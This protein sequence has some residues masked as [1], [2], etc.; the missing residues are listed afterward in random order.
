MVFSLAYNAMAQQAIRYELLPSKDGP[1]AENVPRSETW[2]Q[3]IGHGT[4][5]PCKQRTCCLSS[6]NAP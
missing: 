2:D 4:S 1:V 5:K 3:R 6:D